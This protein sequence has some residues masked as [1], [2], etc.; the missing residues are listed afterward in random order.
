MI[1]IA[2]LLGVPESMAP[3]LLRW[4]NAMV[5]MYQAGAAARWKTPPALAAAEFGD[6]LRGYIDDRRARPAMT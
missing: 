5:G 6:F 3:D 1:I 4:S 2:R